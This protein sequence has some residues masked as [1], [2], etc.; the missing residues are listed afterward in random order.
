[1]VH[2]SYIGIT[3]KW[4]YA[5]EHVFLFMLGYY[6]EALPCTNFC[7]QNHPDPEFTIPVGFTHFQPTFTGYP[8]P[9]HISSPPSQRA[10]CSP[11][12]LW[13][14]LI[15]CT[16]CMALNSLA[17]QHNKT[18]VPTKHTAKKI[19]KFLNYCATHPDAT[20]AFYKSNMI[21]YFYSDA[22]CCSK[23]GAHS[24]YGGFFNW[25]QNLSILANHQKAC[26]C[27]TVCH[28]H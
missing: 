25:D 20:L 13:E 2:Y 21:L 28:P 8:R 15:L 23:P 17:S 5:N 7:T 9:Q 27:S 19:T 12:N 22:S 1:M 11:T 14:V 10:N 6:V 16:M 3:L 18:R 24:R 4:D 26:H